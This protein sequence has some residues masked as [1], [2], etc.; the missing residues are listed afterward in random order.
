MSITAS[1]ANY[2]HVGLCITWNK[3]KL[4]SSKPVTCFDG[5]R[6]Q[7]ELIIFSQY[8]EQ[9]RVYWGESFHQKQFTTFIRF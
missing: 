1:F 5:N 3:D 4:A 6:F 9:I 7:M 8:P 2:Q